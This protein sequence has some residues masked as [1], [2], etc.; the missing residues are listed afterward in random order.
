MHFLTSQSQP[1]RYSHILA[2]HSLGHM[3][4]THIP[5]QVIKER[6]NRGVVWFTKGHENR[7]VRMIIKQT[8]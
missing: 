6:I 8:L 7:K 1:W 4:R 3:A 5:L 2:N